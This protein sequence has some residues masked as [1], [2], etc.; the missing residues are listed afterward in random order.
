[1]FEKK[2]YTKVCIVMDHGLHA[3]IIIYNYL[4]K[5]LCQICHVDDITLMLKIFI[6][7]DGDFKR[8]EMNEIEILVQR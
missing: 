4:I 7:D 5:S 3:T 6:R 1:M 8:Y 2:L